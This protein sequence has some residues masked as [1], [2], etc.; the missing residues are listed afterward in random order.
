MPPRQGAALGKSAPARTPDEAPCIV[1][2][3]GKSAM[4]PSSPAS[5]ANR[6]PNRHVTLNGPEEEA[7][8]DGAFTA[9]LHS[10]AATLK[11]GYE[12]YHRH[13]SGKSPIASLSIDLPYEMYANAEY[14]MLV[15]AE[16][17]ERHPVSLEVFDVD[18]DTL[19]LLAR[20][21]LRR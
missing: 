3:L 15:P 20:V 1:G 8:N 10:W 16:D 9:D 17:G 12:N 14:P 21:D 4:W 13:L 5:S 2:S 7:R 6:S 11:V 19:R 18:D